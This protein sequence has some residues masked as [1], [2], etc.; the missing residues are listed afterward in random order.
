MNS[1]HILLTLGFIA[2][3]YFGRDQQLRARRYQRESERVQR[4]YAKLDNDYQS[5]WDAHEVALEDCQAMT[6]ALVA[7]MAERH[8][9]TRHLTVVREG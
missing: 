4:A 3:V 7:S 6:D 5:L 1:L 9:A 8:P 2:L